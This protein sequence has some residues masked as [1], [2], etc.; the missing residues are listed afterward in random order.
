MDIQYLGHSSF[1][2]QGKNIS[3]V[4]DPFSP[5]EVGLNFPKVKSEIV[6][7]T[8][9]HLDHNRTDLV[10]ETR[11]VIDSPGEYEIGGVTVIGIDSFHDN[12]KGALRGKNTIYSIEV[13][14]IVICHLGDLG[15]KLSEKQI[16]EIGMVEVL[17]VPVGGVYT[18]GPEEAVSVVQSV[19]PK[20]IIPMHYRVEKLKLSKASEMAGV[21]EFIKTMGVKFEKMDK[22]SIK[23]GSLP[24]DDQIVTLLE[25]K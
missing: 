11:M 22:L 5:D 14:D 24:S 2:I 4:I 23:Q 8:H 1:K 13:D 7:V 20:Y 21:D 19:E 9:D 3:L 25:K 12:K 15:H 17:M 18:I 6:L 16:S 10:E